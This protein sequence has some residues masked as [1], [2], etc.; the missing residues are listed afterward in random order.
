MFE[1]WKVLLCVCF[2]YSVSLLQVM[3][4]EEK[5]NI[6]VKRLSETLTRASEDNEKSDMYW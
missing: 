3:Y 4:C 2:L 1:L 6:N 5:M